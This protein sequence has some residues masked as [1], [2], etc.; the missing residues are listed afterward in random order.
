MYFNTVKKIHKNDYY[1]YRKH[2]FNL[3]NIYYK[4]IFKLWTHFLVFFFQQSLSM[5]F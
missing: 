3:L 4:L 2:K 5:K 1:F